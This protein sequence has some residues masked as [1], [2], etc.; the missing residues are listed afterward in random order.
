MHTPQKFTF[1]PLLLILL[2]FSVVTAGCDSGHWDSPSSPATT[3][4]PAVTNAVPNDETVGVAISTSP[5]VTFSELMDPATINGTT[6]TLSDPTN[7]LVA[8]NVAYVGNTATFTPA[9]D[10][11]PSTIYTGRITTGA[12]SL[13]GEPLA[14][15]LI[16]SF[17]TAA[18]LIAPTVESTVPAD[19]AEDVAI[20]SSITMVFS[21]AM[22]P[23]TLN[24]ANFTLVG[25]D[26][27]DVQGDFV[28]SATGNTLVFTP[29]L[30]LAPNSFYTATVTTGATAAL[31]ETLASDAVWT[32]ETA[33]AADIVAPEV[34]LV[35][36]DPEAVGVCTNKAIEANFDEAMNPVS[37]LSPA[38]TFTVMTTT[39]EV[40]VIGVV[41][42]D[43]ANTTATFT[44]DVAL[45]DGTEYTATVST[46]AEDIAGNNLLTAEVWTFIAGPGVCQ[47]P[48]VL[49]RTS[50][51]GVLSN[52]GVTLGGGPN[53]VTGFRVIGNVGIHP[54]G[55]CVGCDTTTVNGII[56]I[57]NVPAQDAM[58]E[59][60]AIYNDAI[61]RTTGVCT[62][63]NSGSLVT[64]PSAACGGGA[65]GVFTPGLYWSASS[66]A[67][68][69]GGTI[70]LDA[71]NDADAVFIFQ[72]EST[73]DTIGGDTHII[74]ANQAKAN[75]VFWV[76]KSSASIGGTTSDFVG[77]VIAQ[78]AI[79]VN[80]GTQMT[81]RAFARTAAVTVQ[82]NAVITV[83]AP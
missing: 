78:V 33:L 34:A 58:T 77:T 56:A 11:A 80:E 73:I 26:T 48:V 9:A 74:L 49:D 70:T 19:D 76:A 21:Q 46:G 7:A 75:N 36:P 81:G 28:Y 18:Q 61:G 30:P 83:P 22:N 38:T 31:G 41:T 66:I 2:L 39:G 17:E 10:L 72:S 52:T 67:I 5:A 8:G 79:T 23:T 62:L 1:N 69:A 47:Q 29:L 3:P 35:T 42:L 4:V 25:S 13:A 32:F 54:T 60:T 27:V 37:L 55:A 65:D 43:A 20:N 40:A 24:D 44:P 53:S 14:D 71:Q 64:N 63:N 45:V 51:Y 6:F 59:L 50:P 82:D 12:E 16:W 57:G 15:D 68:P